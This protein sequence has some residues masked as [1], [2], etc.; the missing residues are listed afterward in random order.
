MNR[1]YK[2]RMKIKKLKIFNFR[3]KKKL[4]SYL[5]C[6]E[7]VNTKIDVF[8]TKLYLIHNT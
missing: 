3:P 8:P 5:Y 6:Y 7:I 1:L 2:K 4:F